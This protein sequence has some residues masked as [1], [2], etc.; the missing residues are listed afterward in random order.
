MAEG[1]GTSGDG[2]KLLDADLVETDGL[3]DQQRDFVARFLRTGSATE[4]RNVSSSVGQKR[5]W[6]AWAKCGGRSGGGKGSLRSP[7][8]AD[9][10]DPSAVVPRVGER[11]KENWGRVARPCCPAASSSLARSLLAP[12]MPLQG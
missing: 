12:P 11:F 9:Q 10:D 6:S 7:A 3:S 2:T 5:S 4:A 8:R 1:N